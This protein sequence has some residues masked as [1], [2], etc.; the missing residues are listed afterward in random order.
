MPLL[1]QG[2]RIGA[3]CILSLSTALSGCSLIE[4]KYADVKCPQ[5]GILGQLSAVSRF[6]GHGTAFSNLGYR[7][8]LGDLTSECKVNN[9]GVTVN[10][11]VS[12][13]AEIGPAASGRSAE[14]PYFIAVTDENDK[15]V[16]KRVL[17][18]EITFKSNQSRAGARDTDN[19][20]I[21]IP[22]PKDAAK[23]HVVIGFQLTP[24]EL[25]Y[26]RVLTAR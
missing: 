9:E 21:P 17:P 3:L 4:G 26:N 8:S 1:S 7:A 2:H 11:T 24:D 14:F 5:A 18:N 19:E 25:A 20:R 10:V 12:T 23:Y 22:D 15:I 6:D 13:L 16:A